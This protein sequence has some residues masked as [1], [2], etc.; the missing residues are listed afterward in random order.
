[1]EI[2]T[3]LCH[4]YIILY[5]KGWEKT[6]CEYKCTFGQQKGREPGLHAHRNARG[7]LGHAISS[8]QG[9]TGEEASWVKASNAQWGKGALVTGQGPHPGSG[10]RKRGKDNARTVLLN[11]QLDVSAQVL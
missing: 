3:A 4:R 1:M 6:N 7:W 10:K 11:Y 8:T 2:Q 5:K 9:E